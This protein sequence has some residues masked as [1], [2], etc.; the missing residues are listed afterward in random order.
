MYVNERERVCIVYIH[1]SVDMEGI[2]IIIIRA[3]IYGRSTI[4][5]VFQSQFLKS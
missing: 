2:S 1:N 4:Y 3:V 5:K